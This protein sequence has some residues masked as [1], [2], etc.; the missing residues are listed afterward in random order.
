MTPDKPLYEKYDMVT[1]SG[2]FFPA[3]PKHIREN[4]SHKLR[5]YQEQA[6]GRWLHY[7]DNDP[8]N[9]KAPVQ[10]LFNMATGSGKT[11]IMAGLIL[12]LYKRGYRNFIYFVNSKNIIEKTR[13]NF[14]NS[15]SS[16]YLFSSS[17]QIDGEKV[18]VREV[19]NFSEADNNAINI[20][21]TT[22]QGLHT[23]L[24]VPRENTLSYEEFGDK[25]IVLIGDEAHHNNSSTLLS[26]DDLED[27]RSWELTISNI[28]NI[29]KES[30]LLEFTA[31]IDLEDP[32][33]CIKYFERTIY[34]YDLKKFRQD[35][36]SKDVFIYD[37]DSDLRS[38]MLQAIII[39]QYRKKVAFRNGIWL[40]PVVL[41]KSK[42]IAEN[43]TNFQM[44]KQL[45]SSLSAND[46]ADQ[47]SD[48]T[49][50]LA[51][52]FQKI[53]LELTD[54]VEELKNDFMPERL[55]LIDGNNIDSDKQIKLNSLEDEDNEIRAIFAVDML[56]EGW[57]V[58][59][60]FD[61]VRLYDTRDARNGAPG[62]TT[63]REAQ[64]I[65]RGARY[66]PFISDNP[67]QKY[68]R[69]FD[70][71]E[72]EELRLIEQLHYHS[73][74]NPKY[75][76]EIRQALVTSGLMDENYIE[77]TLE[78]KESF[79]KTRTYT[80]GVVY[81]NE[82][83]SRTEASIENI[84][85]ATLY[86]FDFPEIV[87][88]SLPTNIGHITSV[89]DEAQNEYYSAGEIVN[90][91]FEFGKLVSANILC[92]AIAKNKAFQFNQISKKIFALN[93]IE[94]F[95]AMVGKV[96]IIATGSKNYQE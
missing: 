12:G 60:L 81:L 70:N 24:N 86:S 68:V 21:F 1:A 39:S 25:K 18:G 35:G 31:T 30:V 22:I 77:R 52:A 57:D 90:L 4:L 65:G 84:R 11:L 42:T 82:R 14:L 34:R 92:H 26:K 40:K 61:I 67:E 58:L 49:N 62:K 95:I 96:K 44:F 80:D 91:E 5:P 27:N 88:I 6:I 66:Y 47:K 48:A 13:D 29:A 19:E 94:E 51:D 50:I 69:K 15:G 85:K 41:F 74:S 9:K 54:I 71:N 56:N 78:L 28:M 10:L 37:V 46:L 73:A 2:I 16:K 89:F 20:I 87:E 45:I 17:I 33:I 63:I 36:Y 55:L 7:M 8:L 76:Q 53:N 59:N 83:V 79:K 43:K 23:D 93:S 64:L 38:R 75:I 72:N 32:N 3:A